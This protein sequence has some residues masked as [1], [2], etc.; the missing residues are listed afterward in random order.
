MKTPGLLAAAFRGI[1]LCSIAFSLFS[2]FAYGQDSRPLTEDDFYKL[3][4][5]PVPDG[6][7]LEV[8]GLAVMPDGRV[9]VSTR[10]GDVYVIQNPYGN[11]QAHFTRF[12]TGLHEPLGLAYKNG[13]FYLSQRGELTR[14]RD[15]DGDG[16]ADEYE[17]LTRWPLDGNYHEYSY[18]PEWLPNGDMLITLNLA[19]IGRGASLSKWRGWMLKYNEKGEVTPYA[20]G[21]R[22][23]AGYAVTRSG[24]IFYAENQGDWVGSGRITHL[25]K[26]DFAGNPSGLRWSGEPGS[27]VKLKVS[28]IPDTG[29]PMFNVAKKVPGLKPPAVWFPH[30]L[31]GISTSD[32]VEDTTG[33]G[34]GPFQGQLFVGDQGHSKVMRVFLEKVNGK[35]QGA[36]FAFR[37][38]M[39]SGVLRM[40]WGLDGSMF[41]G[42][43]SRGWSAT[44]KSAFALQRVVWT[45]KMPFEIKAVRAMPD[46][47]ELE[48]TQPVDTK[49]ASDAGAYS[50]TNFTYRYHH[51]YGSPIQDSKPCTIRGVIV[52]PDGLKA[53]LAVDGL[54]EGYIHEVLAPGVKSAQNL[55]LL[56][57]ASYY[58]LNAIPAGERLAIAAPA[59]SAH[60][61][62]SGKMTGGNGGNGSS[63]TT[64]LVNNT[65]KT[66]AAAPAAK[67]ITAMPEG[68]GG[69][70]DQTINVGTLPGLKFDRTSLTVKAGSKIKVVFNNNDD[71]LHNF[72]VV[73]PGTA[74][75]VGD[76]AIKMGLN[77]PQQNYIPNTPKVLYHSAVLQ[78]ESSEAIY[79]EAPSKPGEYTYVC[80]MPGHAYV[81][82]GTLKVVKE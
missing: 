52:S 6:V 33:G 16:R 49:T 42:Q 14:L 1:T 69:K 12:A 8:G 25:E 60:A 61:G 4:T 71:M 56:H 54:K 17:A 45:G 27:P 29:E 66:N 37:E 43:T 26:G 18:G 50:V 7:P 58:T 3:V 63:G 80:T 76:M 24:D 34:F 40:A 74:V 30:S 20:T 68:W 10:R 51:F 55:P 64:K 44:G 82:Q 22:S 53:R 5:V 62:H 67:R 36:C 57:T 46:G 38:G 41:V 77:G 19:W 31:M 75:E 9:G 81:M 72:V 73:L 65:A 39:A 21:L 79:F 78:P 70:V 28:D 15:T 47:F 23:P 48:F 11:G 32:I 2:G 13:N 59:A 35:Y